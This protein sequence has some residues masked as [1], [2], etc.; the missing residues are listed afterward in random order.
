MALARDTHAPTK[1][2]DLPRTDGRA[3][4][5]LPFSSIS[6]Y[7]SLS[8]IIYGDNR[9]EHLTHIE[10]DEYGDMKCE[11]FR[12]EGMITGIFYNDE[13]I[14][15]AFRG[16]QFR[17]PKEI[18][19]F[20]SPS[21]DS[22]LEEQPSNIQRKYKW[23]EIGRG[24]QLQLWDSP[25]PSPIGGHISNIADKILD[26]KVTLD[27]G[28]DERLYPCIR[29]RLNE[30]RKLHPE[31]TVDVI[32]HSLGGMMACAFAGR[33][34]ERYPK[35]PIENIVTFSQPRTGNIAFNE[36]LESGIHG[37]YARCAIDKDVMSEAPSSPNLSIAKLPS[38]LQWNK[39]DSERLG[40]RVHGGT[41]VIFYTDEERF[42]NQADRESYGYAERHDR[43]HVRVIT[44]PP[45]MLL[46]NK[47]EVTAMR[48]H[49]IN[50]HHAIAEHLEK[51]ARKS[52]IIVHEPQ[53][54]EIAKNTH[55]P[56]SEIK[57]AELI[58]PL[59]DIAT[60]SEIGCRA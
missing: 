13:K 34:L 3:P 47:L 1:S 20:V 33:Y 25:S 31:A 2:F 41:G 59:C 58:A 14:I 54:I 45:E 37:V 18:K 32:G 28:E 29:K 57:A 50:S 39:E 56:R 26:S 35:K 40:R 49:A 48:R 9:L 53:E 19:N 21:L 51:S 44:P 60:S 23:T 4:Y 8:N 52:H 10:S 15:V 24:F 36:A 38:P 55:V 6:F 17:V 30:M 11:F 43:P 42:R 22:H 27:N 5:R 46:G 12:N 7:S 16:S